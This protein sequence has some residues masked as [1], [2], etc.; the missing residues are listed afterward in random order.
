[1]AVVGS[2]FMAVFIGVV[3]VV[4]LSLVFMENIDVFLVGSPRLSFPVCLSELHP[5]FLSPSPCGR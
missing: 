4:R 1:M 5:I 3:N 2:S